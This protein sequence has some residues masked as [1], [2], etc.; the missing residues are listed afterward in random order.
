MRWNKKL[1]SMTIQER[2]RLREKEKKCVLKNCVFFGKKE[3]PRRPPDRPRMR[4]SAAT[5]LP[6]FIQVVVLDLQAKCAD[7]KYSLRGSLLRNSEVSSPYLVF[8]S[9]L[10][11][12]FSSTH[13][14]WRSNTTTCMK[15]GST[16]AAEL[17]MRG[18]SG[19]LRGHPFSRVLGSG[20]GVYI[21]SKPLDSNGVHKKFFHEL[22]KELISYKTQYLCSKWCSAHFSI[23]DKLYLTLSFF[24]NKQK[25]G[26]SEG[27]CM[28]ATIPECF[29]SNMLTTPPSPRSRFWQKWN[30][31]KEC[32]RIFVV[33]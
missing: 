9:P 29:K 24:E 4:S 16:V 18:R 11:E 1:Q 14:A 2:C 13:F 32:M 12:Y 20:R 21:A 27:C 31:K 22:E 23:S 5:V 3:C 28:S 6:N 7:E 26:F 25:I 10:K 17:R 19:G 30:I 8:T 15:F 33:I